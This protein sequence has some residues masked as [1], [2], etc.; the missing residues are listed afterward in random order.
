M[1]RKITRKERV[2]DL[3]TLHPATPPYG[4]DAD[5]IARQTGIDR[6]NV[7]KELN[8]LFSEKRAIKIKGKP[9]RYLPAHDF[10]V[11]G[12]EKCLFENQADFE[13]YVQLNPHPIQGKAAE[14]GLEAP[15]IPSNATAAISENI[16]SLIVGADKSL[17]DQVALAKAAVLYPP[18]GLHTLI[19]GYTGVGKSTFAE[20]MFQ[21]AVSRGKLNVDAPFIIFNCADYYN[22]PQLLISQIF[23]HI[24]GAFTGADQEKQGL[25]EHANG[26]ILFLDEVHRLPPEGQEMLFLLMDKGV[27]RKLGETGTVHKA[28][29][30]IIAATTENPKST[31]LATF[32]RRIPTVIT[33]PSL[34]ERS[35]EERANLISIFFWEESRRINLPIRAARDVL[36]AFM[37]YRCPGNIGQLKSDIQVICAK[38]FLDYLSNEK[39]Q[40]EVQ[41]YH[42]SQEL[43]EGLFNVKR[44]RDFQKYPIEV[45]M[46]DLTFDFRKK[47][48]ETFVIHPLNRSEEDPNYYGKI[49]S[50]W[51][52]YNMLGL[53]DS[54]IQR[55]I[56]EDLDQYIGRFY[57]DS[58]QSSQAQ[59]ISK[60]VDTNIIE[61]VK[62]VLRDVEPLSENIYS[63][64]PICG[65]SLHVNNLL[66]RL[67]NGSRVYHPDRA[68]IASEYPD[69]YQTAERIRTLLSDQLKIVIPEDES[70]FITMLLYAIK[71]TKLRRSIGILVIAHGN[72]VASSMVEIVNR[73]LGINHAQAIDMPLEES[74]DSIL[75]KATEKVKQMD[76]GKGVLLL[77]DMGS[78]L[79][80]SKMITEKTGILTRGIDKVNTVMLL[81]ATRKAYMGNLEIDYLVEDLRKHFSVSDDS[82][83]KHDVLE[84]NTLDY[85]QYN[86]IKCLEKMLVF[87]NPN[88][89]YKI[90]QEVLSIL[91]EQF[92]F[93]IDNDFEVK[94]L[95]HVS[96]MIERAIKKETLFHK[97][98]ADISRARGAVLSEIRAAFQIVEEAFD[99]SIPNTELIYVLE[100]FDTHFNTHFDTL[101]QIR[102]KT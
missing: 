70:A 97:D 90:L 77:V 40:L 41:L 15:D 69:E 5:T 20:A 66:D 26:G 4:V 101:Q 9:V 55:R 39:K 54:D 2:F 49:I 52:R 63:D 68:A 78:L 27:Y 100:M 51:Q 48:I 28:R 79:Y 95:F 32:L 61:I 43:Q 57:T 73:I 74:V 34:E 21:Y 94:F 3:L 38:A 31:M 75:V 11:A 59:A 7:S 45:F 82:N 42:M 47:S 17:R 92:G 67:K 58:E 35:L 12:A 64:R 18:N 22:N 19:V 96:C 88:K 85:F 33:L 16:F 83:M 30:L 46:K 93:F 56:N 23:G 76:C 29:I 99:V 25:V 72:S 86:L 87:L 14:L 60:I 98:H 44:K 10:I 84:D 53:S 36:H 24:K 102:Y 62:N 8:K 13:K 6:S 1:T 71:S 91:S 50:N 89:V 81:E 65:L 80:F 37:F